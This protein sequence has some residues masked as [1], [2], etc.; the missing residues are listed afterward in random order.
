[1]I[2]YSSNNNLVLILS[3]VGGVIL[4]AAVLVFFLLKRNNKN[5]YLTKMD[6]LVSLVNIENKS[7]IDA[8]I[9]RLANI[10]KKN[11][12]Y[13]DISKMIS[14]RFEDLMTNEKEKLVVRHKGLKERILNE[15]KI[16]KGLLDQIKS[17]ESAVNQYVKEV[18]QIQKDLEN[19]FIEGDR[20][21][22]RLTE[23]Q[24]KYQQILSDLDKYSSAIAICKN[25]LLSYL[26]D[27]EMY[28]DVF[29]GNLSSAK[30]KEADKN[31]S[32]I[33]EMVM[34]LYG[35]IER[36]ARYC[37]M[38]DEVIPNQLE[39]LFYKN[40]ELEEQGYVVS[41]AKVN[42]FIANVKTLL[43]SCKASFKRLYFSEFEDISYDIQNK[44][45][46]VHA[47]LDQEVVCKHELDEKYQQVNDKFAFA[48]S[49]FISTK[50]SFYL[51]LDFYKLP[52]EYHEKFQNFQSNATKLTDLKREYDESIFVNAKNPA[53]YMLI[54]VGKIETVA[55]EVLDDIK[56]F[57]SYFN[58][59]KEY[60][61][62][63]FEKTHYLLEEI[64]KSI[65]KVRK[66]KCKPVYEKYIDKANNTLDLLKQVNQLL[67]KKPIEIE[68][69]HQSFA[70]LVSNAE[71][72]IKMINND[73]ENYN[74]VEKCIIFA[75]PLRSQFV[76]VDKLLREIEELFVEGDYIQAQEK[77]N[78]ILNNYHP[79]A[80][81]SFNGK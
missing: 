21:R 52:S 65:G 58:T 61:E 46:E 4:A 30:Y 15:K 44:L 10:A 79:A 1:M 64:T 7:Q 81:D 55:D 75:N 68:I 69:L 39:E 12:N 50:R 48:S 63:T 3:I 32:N 29:D 13:V 72:L 9:T 26:S 28:F 77:L 11:E 31:L 78:Y 54:K 42:E 17:F 25:E 38:V 43:E 14:K 47:R 49:E 23:L 5:K 73:L 60:V 62:N 74:M 18:K 33:E 2:F 34:N 20:L 35:Y 76:E 70:S 41:H 45:A 6:N 51:M 71:E 57:N 8:Y 66:S 67:L 16:K 59:T 19:Y 53:S 40:A 36:I 24:D 80:F 27:V 22:V 56:F 37:N